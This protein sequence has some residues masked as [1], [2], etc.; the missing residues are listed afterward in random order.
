MCPN[1]QLVRWSLC[2]ICS[3]AP[4]ITQCNK[5]A[6][7]FS[8]WIQ[9]PRKLLLKSEKE[10]IM[11]AQQSNTH[12]KVRLPLRFIWAMLCSYTAWQMQWT[13]FASEKDAIPIWLLVLSMKRR[14]KVAPW[15]LLCTCCDWWKGTSQDEVMSNSEEVKPIALTIVEI[16]LAEGIS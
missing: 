6:R 3:Y 2:Y 1:N 13:H 16:C 10:A 14:T 15:C 11:H 8:G 9:L 7:N 5:C 4:L 12:W